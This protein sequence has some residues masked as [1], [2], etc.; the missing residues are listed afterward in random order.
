MSDPPPKPLWLNILG[1]LR[2]SLQY[3]FHPS[4]PSQFHFFSSENMT[5]VAIT[6]YYNYYCNTIFHSDVQVI[7]FVAKAM[8]ASLCVCFRDGNFRI[9]WREICG[10]FLITLYTVEGETSGAISAL[11]RLYP[12][13]ELLISF[14]IL[15]SERLFSFG[16]RPVLLA[17]P[18][19]SGF[20]KFI[21]I[22]H[23]Q[24]KYGCK[25]F[26]PWGNNTQP[27]GIGQFFSQFRAVIIFVHYKQLSD[28]ALSQKVFFREAFSLKQILFN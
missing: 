10:A 16:L 28:R 2:K 18:Y 7:L 1:S 26:I 12:L 17:L 13:V 22:V 8:R 19:C 21:N 3:E 4:G 23:N 25:N 27:F 11:I 20:Y 14:K 24:N 9:R 15:R 5:Y 6:Y